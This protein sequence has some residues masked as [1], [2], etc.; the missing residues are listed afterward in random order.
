MR[1]D[2]S[3]SRAVTA[4]A[5]RRDAARHL[6][7]PDQLRDSAALARQPS[8]RNS[9]LAGLQAAITS[10]IALPLFHLSPWSHLIGFASLGALVA[11]FGRFA[12]ARRRNRI[13]LL[14]GIWQVLAVLVMSGAAWMGAP[15]ALQLLLLAVSCGV[16]L[17]VAVTGRFGAPG[18]LIFVFA[19][20]A[21]MSAGGLTGPEVVERVLATATVAALA[22]L[23]CTVT[24]AFR[25]HPTPDH[26]LPAEP[27]RPLSHRLAAAARSSIAAGIAVFLGHVLGADHPAWA[28]MGALAV[29]QGA[30]LHITMNRALQRMAGTVVGSLLAWVLLVQDPSVWTLIA[31]LILLQVATEMVIGINYAFGQILVTP[32]ALLMTH[33]AAP[34]GAGP[35]LVPERVLDTL[36]G[37]GAGIVIAVLLSTMDDRRYLAELRKEAADT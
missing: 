5:R 2:R 11:L 20:G 29:M 22:L 3:G 37:A 32:M 13:V 27:V 14:C 34:Q 10:A 4:R 21:S 35:A 19:A 1:T 16:F 23:V 36:L 12:P 17:F 18:P 9:A 8:L 30:H 7:H 15:V 31:V 25:H 26:P 33:L 24:E 28:A 6:L